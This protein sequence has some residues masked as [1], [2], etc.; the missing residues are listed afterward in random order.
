[1]TGVSR[2]DWTTRRALAADAA[3]VAELGSRMFE[4]AFGDLNDPRD[5]ADYL[6]AS[7]G[8]DI[9]RA[10][11]ERPDSITLL[12]EASGELVGYAQ[13]EMLAPESLVLAAPVQL[14]RMY[15][16]RRFHGSGLAT[17]LMAA[18][19]EAAQQLGGRT[20]WLSVWDRNER[21][22]AFYRKSGFDVVGA[23]VFVVGSDPQT[24]HLMATRLDQPD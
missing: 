17:A 10:E 2:P 23:A 6:A 13:V 20:L 5:T 1:M 7:F 18:V 14:H 22:I 11:I 4:E 15:V 3:A 16:D 21:A 24:D 8:E 12:V 19:K 9:Q